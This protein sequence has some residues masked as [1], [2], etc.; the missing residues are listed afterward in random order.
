MVAQH[1][2]RMVNVTYEECS[3]NM[4]DIFSLEGLFTGKEFLTKNLNLCQKGARYASIFAF[5]QNC[6]GHWLR[7]AGE[8]Q[9][10]PRGNK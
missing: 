9:F 4:L 5:T 7:N 3:S 6:F 1:F 2:L 8:Q 10:C